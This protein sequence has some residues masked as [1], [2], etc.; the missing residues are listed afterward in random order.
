MALKGRPSSVK[1]GK[2]DYTKPFQDPGGIWSGLFGG[3]PERPDLDP[4]YNE[5]D[6]LYGSLMD[7]IP[8]QNERVAY[9]G[10][11]QPYIERQGPSA[12]E[13]IQTN[14]QYRN[15]QIA[16]LNALEQQGQEGLTLRDK[17]DRAELEA[18]VNRQNAG[19]LGAIRSN[20]AQRGF[21]GSGLEL[22][23]AQQAA[24]DATQRQFQG[25]LDQAA[26][27]EARKAQA[28][29][30]LGSMG[31]AMQGQDFAQQSQKAQAI[32]AINRFNVANSMNARNEAERRNADM[33]QQL[34]Q[35]NAASQNAFNQRAYENKYQTKGAL[36]NQNAAK[37]NEAK[38]DY[39]SAVNQRERER[40]RGWKNLGKVASIGA[41]FIPSDE[42]RKTD[43]ESLSDNDI[44]DFLNSIQPKK[45]RYKNPQMDGH[46]QRVGIIAQDIEGSKVGRDIVKDSEDGKQL[47]VSNLLG[48]ILDAVGLLNRKLDHA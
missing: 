1:Y 25:G 47:D 29:R 16:A 14:P 26:A 10:D 21:G 5:Q 36:I 48:A 24:E 11:Y 27:A 37:I 19:R 38:A 35:Q 34:A 7:D 45:F 46:G 2:T 33:R 31:T 3:D 9:Q 12:A 20:M 18:E 6:Q 32:D 42:D 30:D 28:L 17:A 41:S 8:T 4:W 22:V 13:N 44:E 39:Q 40:S 43:I 15:A 23:S